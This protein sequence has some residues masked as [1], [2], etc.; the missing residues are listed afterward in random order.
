MYLQ[1]LISFFII[2]NGC[3]IKRFDSNKITEL[4]KHTTKKNDNRLL[5]LADNIDKRNY[6]AKKSLLFSMKQIS[7][8]ADLQL[9]YVPIIEKSQLYDFTVYKDDI[10]QDYNHKIPN[11][12]EKNRAYKFLVSQY[13]NTEN[14]YDDYEEGAEG[15]RQYDRL[16]KAAWAI[17][18]AAWLRK[19]G[20]A[21]VDWLHFKY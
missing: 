5:A 18:R 16:R 3:T 7:K 8:E 11:I 20:K 1:L 19:N 12:G 4:S 17:E 14:P 6:S 2:L 10:A 9:S 13:E 15:S 21:T